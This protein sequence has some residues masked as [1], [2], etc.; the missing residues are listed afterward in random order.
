[1]DEKNKLSESILKMY[2]CND[3][4]IDLIANYSHMHTQALQKQDTQTDHD[5]LRSNVLSSK[6]DNLKK[7]CLVSSNHFDN[8]M[9]F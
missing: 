2:L 6:I 4:S 9:A 8:S 3:V 1:M 7:D 5:K